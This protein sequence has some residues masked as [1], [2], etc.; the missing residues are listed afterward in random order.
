MEFFDQF[1]GEDSLWVY[2]Y[3][4]VVFL[5]GILM[6]YVIWGLKTGRLK[7]ENK[8]KDNTIKDLEVKLAAFLE[9]RDSHHADMKRLGLELRTNQKNNQDLTDEKNK[10]QSQLALT[11]DSVNSLKI[12]LNESNTLYEELTAKYQEAN[13]ELNKMN[14]SQNDNSADF[15]ALNGRIDSL[16]RQNRELINL[17]IREKDVYF[18]QVNELNSSFGELQL[19]YESTAEQLDLRSKQLDQL[20]SELALMKNTTDTNQNS[21]DELKALQVKY[22]NQKAEFN[23]LSS[24]KDYYNA[25]IETLQTEVEALKA[26]N[27]DLANAK[28]NAYNS[29]VLSL[30]D[31][32]ESATNSLALLE[33]EKLKAQKEVKALKKQIRELEQAR[34]AIKTQYE[35]LQK[36]KNITSSSNLIDDSNSE[37]HSK[38]VALE[39]QLKA[40]L[41]TNDATIS[42]ANAEKESLELS[43]QA[44][45]IELERA[46]SQVSNSNNIGGDITVLVEELRTEI[47]RLEDE[48]RTEQ[49]NYIK[50]FNELK[51][52]HEE[53]LELEAQKMAAMKDEKTLFQDSY[54]ELEAKVSNLETTAFEAEEDLKEANLSFRAKLAIQNKQVSNVR[55]ENMNLVAEINTLKNKIRNLEISPVIVDNHKDTDVLKEISTNPTTNMNENQAVAAAKKAVKDL[56]GKEIPIAS[57]SDKDDLKI[58]NGIGAFIEQ[59]LNDLGIYA[60]EQIAVFDKDIIEKVTDAIQFFPGRIERDEWVAQAQNLSENSEG[61]LSAAQAKAAIKAAIGT[62]ISIATADEKDN[63]K[64]IKGIGSFI[65]KKLNNLGI[66][67]FEQVS[68]LDEELV[69]TITIAIEFFPGRIARDRWV[70]Q[71]EKLK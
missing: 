58:I 53:L 21:T 56:I 8:A 34:Q 43:I 49:Q 11:R 69:E 5:L 51:A 23:H 2:F 44:L 33:G 3:L 57:V 47:N 40:T 46:K 65:E 27:N 17:R 1:A 7:R 36:E 28:D 41:S 20:K 70:Q 12:Q 37:L 24:K 48:K 15:D 19:V 52:N 38:I 9:E 60:F 6:G 66:Y 62:K 10:W 22:N 55:D 13:M 16:E 63:L 31:S 68:Q 71:A 50:E 35:T 42:T 67:T 30:Q 25:Q 14:S 32:L 45:E 64:V 26:K 29:Q 39:S 61:G 54:E 4:F 18:T 59:K